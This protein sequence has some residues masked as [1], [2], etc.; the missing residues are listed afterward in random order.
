MR[1]NRSSS[2]ATNTAGG[3]ISRERRI[4]RWTAD[5]QVRLAG[6]AEAYQLYRADLQGVKS[7]ILRT[8]ESKG[9]VSVCRSIEEIVHTWMNQKCEALARASGCTGHIKICRYKLPRPLGVLDMRSGCAWAASS[10]GEWSGTRVAL[11]VEQT[12]EGVNVPEFYDEVM[13]AAAGLQAETYQD[14]ALRLGHAFCLI[15]QVSKENGESLSVKRRKGRIVVE[16]GGVGMRLCQLGQLTG[17]AQVAQT[18]EEESGGAG[19]VEIL[20]KSQQ[21]LTQPLSELRAVRRRV[22]AA[23]GAE[24]VLYNDITRKSR[25]TCHRYC[26]RR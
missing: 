11:V 6:F 24:A 19:L 22:A 13:R 15:S 20:R 5:L 7:L 1:A 14:A 10:C 25:F 9:E 16:R 23:K 8:Y 18:F 12:L 21:E 2:Q 4:R 17:L 26:S 3:F